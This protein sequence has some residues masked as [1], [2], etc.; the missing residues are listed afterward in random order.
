MGV[1]VR[2]NRQRGLL[3]APLLDDP[4]TEAVVLAD[5]CHR[6]T[7][8][9]LRHP[10]LQKL[11]IHQAGYGDHRS[12]ERND[13]RRRL[14]ATMMPRHDQNRRVEA[15]EQC[16]LQFRIGFGEIEVFAPVLLV[17]NRRH[18]QR[19]AHVS[20][21]MAKGLLGDS[22]RLL[23]VSRDT[24]PQD[25]LGR[26]LPPLREKQP[27]ECGNAA[28]EPIRMPLAKRQPSNLKRQT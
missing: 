20:A 13:I 27:K 11:R 16:L 17:D 12:F 7:K 1:L 6:A 22:P 24:S 25:V 9:M 19:L 5:D 3:L 21:E 2:Q 14:P 4:A 8:M 28:P 15:P 18:D 10:V 23:F 26:K